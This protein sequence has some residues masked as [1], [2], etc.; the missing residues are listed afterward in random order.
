MKKYHLLALIIIMIAEITCL[1]VS[2]D[3]NINSSSGAYFLRAG[4]S[5]PTEDINSGGFAFSLGRSCRLIDSLY[6]EAEGMLSL[7]ESDFVINESVNSIGS[8]ELKLASININMNYYFISSDS[9]KI[10]LKAGTGYCI[11]TISPKDIYEEL[12]FTIEE[13]LD[14]SIHFN[15]GFG[16]DFSIFDNIALNLDIRYTLNSV[17]GTWYVKDEISGAEIF[18]NTDDSLNFITVLL[19]IKFN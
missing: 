18:G 16:S 19:G 15:F 5:F 10:Y 2:G 6:I 4:Y 13:S 12:G 14:D 3:E 1:P 7:P 8:G 9:F 11:N 17:T